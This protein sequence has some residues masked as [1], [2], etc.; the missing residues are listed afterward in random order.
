MLLKPGAGARESG[1]WAVTLGAC[2]PSGIPLAV[3]LPRASARPSPPPTSLR[4]CAALARAFQSERHAARQ[5]T[6]S[7][8]AESASRVAEIHSLF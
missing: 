6:V 7:G 3:V 2:P 4:F 5:Y 8:V 1:W